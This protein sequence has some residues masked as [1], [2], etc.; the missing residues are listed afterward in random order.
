MVDWATGAFDKDVEYTCGAGN[1]ALELEDRDIDTKGSMY[2][3]GTSGGT[4][5]LVF[6]LLMITSSSV[7]LS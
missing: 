4:G 3:S 1:E 7:G 6:V 2:S 5:D